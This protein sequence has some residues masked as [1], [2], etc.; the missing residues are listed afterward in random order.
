[1]KAAIKDLFALTVLEDAVPRTSSMTKS[2]A[3]PWISF[4]LFGCGKDSLDPKKVMEDS[5]RTTAETEKMI[6]KIKKSQ[7]EIEAKMKK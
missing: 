7:A 3:L 1:M 4:L 2:C 6:E 5:R